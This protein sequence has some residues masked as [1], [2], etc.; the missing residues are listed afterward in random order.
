MSVSVERNGNEATLKINLPVEDV[1]K[2]FD[3]AV[4]K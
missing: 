2:V 4:A 3:K 1:A